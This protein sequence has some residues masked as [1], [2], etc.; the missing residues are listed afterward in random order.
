MVNNK[1]NKVMMEM[2]GGTLTSPQKVG[3]LSEVQNVTL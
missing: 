1:R 2:E 3:F